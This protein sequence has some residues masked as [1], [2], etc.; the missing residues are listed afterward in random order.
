MIQPTY[1][2]SERLG[3]YCILRALSPRKNRVLL[4]SHEQYLNP[5]KLIIH[6]SIR[7]HGRR[8]KDVLK[9]TLMLDEPEIK[10]FGLRFSGSRRLIS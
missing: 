1:Y 10:L 6:D 9:I 2:G 7:I 4:P 5:L 3:T 8:K